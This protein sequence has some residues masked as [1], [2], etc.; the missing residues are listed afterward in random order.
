VLRGA[1]AGDH[2]FALGVDQEL[3]VELVLAGGRVAGEGDA[4][5]ESSPMLPKTIDCTLTAVPFRPR[6][7][8]I[9]R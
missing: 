3:A 4:G 9:S 8:S 6:M 5:A 7:F 2:V 1:D